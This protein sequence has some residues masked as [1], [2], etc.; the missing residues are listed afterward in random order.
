MLETHEVKIK[1]A[2][3]GK[4]AGDRKT[5]EICG[6]VLANFG[7]QSLKKALNHKGLI[8]QGNEHDLRDSK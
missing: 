3:T 1:W 4:L 8:L 5:Q 6:R 7:L 2:K